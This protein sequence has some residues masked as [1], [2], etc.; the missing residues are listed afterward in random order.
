MA[1]SSFAKLPLELQDLI[2]E[3]CVLQDTAHF[4]RLRYSEF[5]NNVRGGRPRGGSLPDRATLDLERT[6]APHSITET[7]TVLLQTTTRSR[8]AVLGQKEP[9][10]LGRRCAVQKIKQSPLPGL[11][12]NA[13]A[14]MVVLNDNWPG[15]TVGLRATV[16]QRVKSPNQLRY[17]AVPWSPSH[18]ESVD[19]KNDGWQPLHRAIEKLLVLYWG[20]HVLYVLVEPEILQTST[21]PWPE[22]MGWEPPYPGGEPVSLEGYLAAY[23]EGNSHTTNFRSGNREYFEVP[24]E[25]VLHLG[26]LENII[27]ALE[28]LRNYRNT[29]NYGPGASATLES[30]KEPVKLR[31]MSWKRV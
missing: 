26:G 29:F 23:V 14:D 27:C 3:F 25:K 1:F 7:R 30:R 6:C 16:L 19:F 12:I 11:P 13:A 9:V 4:A 10:F 28:M 2:W 15:V 8:A 5:F 18:P 22:N 21:Q 31:L 24:A 20:L 17:L